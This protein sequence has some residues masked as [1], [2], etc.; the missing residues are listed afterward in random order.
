MEADR[1]EGASAEAGADRGEHKF[2]STT[3]RIKPKGNA[4]GETDPRRMLMPENT[5][6]VRRTRL[7]STVIIHYMYVLRIRHFKRKGIII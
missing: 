7:Q 6:T 1:A 2:P 3:G 5:D 4:R